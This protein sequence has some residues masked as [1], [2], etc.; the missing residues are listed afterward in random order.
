M[1]DSIRVMRFVSPVLLSSA[2][3]KSS[4]RNMVGVKCP[5]ASELERAALCKNPLHSFKRVV[6]TLLER[7][8]CH[9]SCHAIYTMPWNRNALP[10]SGIWV[11]MQADSNMHAPC[12]MHSA[13]EV[14]FNL[15]AH[16]QKAPCSGYGGWRSGEQGVG[17]EVVWGSGG[18]TPVQ[19][20]VDRPPAHHQLQPPIFMY[21]IAAPAACVRRRQEGG[22]F[23]RH[24][25][26][27]TQSTA[28]SIK[29]TS[30]CTMGPSGPNVAYT[31]GGMVKRWPHVSM[32]CFSCLL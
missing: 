15:T 28:D 16:L 23:F 10:V 27:T 26:H 30:Y 17:H 9:G 32:R 8:P 7:Q 25:S 29:Y 2:L 22:E 4:Q 1:C 6:S 13:K 19:A 12:P 24:V 20:P 31:K 5:L 21:Y 14:H 3:E 18:P 11:Y